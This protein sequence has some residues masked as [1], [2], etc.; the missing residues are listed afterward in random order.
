M[1]GNI[2]NTDAIGARV[3]L[4][5]GGEKMIR[6]VTAG[7]SSMGQNM[8]E[9]HFGLGEFNKIDGLKINWPSGIVQYLNDLQINQYLVIE[10]QSN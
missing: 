3:E 7:S 5:V 4:E 9:V 2:S 6:E 10:E 1:I 8:I